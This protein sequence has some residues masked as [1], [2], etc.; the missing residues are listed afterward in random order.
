M[1]QRD[2]LPE[3]RTVA[4]ARAGAALHGEEEGAHQGRQAADVGQ[5][6]R[7]RPR[8]QPGPRQDA[9]AHDPSGQRHL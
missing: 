5:G 7:V 3:R 8:Q 4:A 6:A 2:L 1:A 9:T